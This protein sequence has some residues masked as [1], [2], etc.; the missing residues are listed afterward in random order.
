MP[1]WA[2]EKITFLNVN[3]VYEISPWEISPRPGLAGLAQLMSLLKAERAA[4]RHTI[5][6]F[7]G[8]DGYTG[9]TRGKPLI[10]PPGAE[11][12]ANMVIDHIA[13]RGT[14]APTI[15]GRITVR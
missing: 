1:V 2:A 12:M 11:L 15:E 7:G 4:N 8:G 3:D 13:A 10:D 5:T 9:R 14:G 6:T